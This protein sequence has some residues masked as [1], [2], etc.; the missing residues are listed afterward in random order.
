MR[1]YY[2]N[3]KEIEEIGEGWR[4]MRLYNKFGL[5]EYHRQLKLFDT[6]EIDEVS[7]T[8]KIT[9]CASVPTKE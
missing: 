1:K 7:V 6:G 2:L 5:K 4:A 9:R 3:N 8:L